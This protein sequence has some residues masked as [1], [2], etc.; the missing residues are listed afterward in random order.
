MFNPEDV[1]IYNL[2]AIGFSLRSD[3]FE[4]TARHFIEG[5]NGIWNIADE[6]IWGK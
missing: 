2:H 4:S 6:L 1:Y 5:L 3:V